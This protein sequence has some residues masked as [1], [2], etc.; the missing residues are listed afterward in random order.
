VCPTQPIDVDLQVSRCL[1][2]LEQNK[3]AALAFY[4]R[5]GDH[6]SVGHVVKLA[7]ML[8]RCVFAAVPRATNTVITAR[9]RC[10]TAALQLD[11]SFIGSY[12]RSCV[13]GPRGQARRHAPPL[14]LRRS[15]PRH[16]HGNYGLITVHTRLF[17]HVSRR[18]CRHAPLRYLR[19][20]APNYQHGNPLSDYLRRYECPALYAAPSHLV[21]TRSDYR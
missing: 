21:C 5:M 10:Y 19:R 9:L 1:T 20:G 14:C 16:Q 13:G 4:S 7:V 12:G 11:S 3:A 8:L 15:A 6:V 17:T 18:A 2:V